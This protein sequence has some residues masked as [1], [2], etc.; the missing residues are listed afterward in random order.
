MRA[1]LLR[2]AFAIV[3]VLLGISVL[4]FGLSLLAP[5]DPA[6]A[7]YQQV[8][9]QP[10]PNS[11]ELDKIRAAYGLNDPAP[12][13][14][15]RWLLAAVRGD[16]GDSLRTGL[17]VLQELLTNSV[18]SLMLAVGGLAL[19]ALIAFPV[20]ILSAVRHNSAADV[21]ARLLSLL[22]A[23]MP[24]FWLAYL[25]ILLF[26]VQ[27]RWL[28]VGGTGELRHLVLP[29]LTLG[30]GGAAALSR[31]IRSVMLEALGEDYVRTARAKGAP[32]HVVV[33][34]H[35]LRNALIPI[36]TTL[37][38]MFAGVLAGAVIVEFVFAVPGI[39]SLILSAISFRDY[40]MIQGF[41][42]YAGTIF[43]VINFIV[44]ALYVW[45]NPAIKLNA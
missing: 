5:G 36:V 21:L 2:R 31:L 9:G 29:C 41:V 37:S 8:Y 45:I 27:L 25:L 11:E 10:A 35:A 12:V 16:L 30:L 18:H 24:S 42:V 26:A 19:A 6:P 44:D 38:G 43:V 34:R 7:I 22:G 28:P 32:E 1:Y 13:R 40:P 15:M 20:G 3:P 14:Y 23:S 33:L 39:G 4:A 17:P